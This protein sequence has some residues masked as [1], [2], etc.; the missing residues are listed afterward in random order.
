[1]S[2]TGNP[3]S[4]HTSANYNTG[5]SAGAG[6]ATDGLR[7]GDQILSA[8]LT[9]ILEGVHGNGIVMLEG[10]AVSGTNRNNPD[11]LPG[12][13][14][15]GTGQH[16]LKIQGGFVVLD[17]S[18]YKFADGYEND[19]TPDEITI[20]L[21]ANS[22]HKTGVTTALTS[23][24][25][26]IFT[27][28]LNADDGS[29]TKHVKFIQSSVVDTGTGVYPSSPNAYLID[30]GTSTSVKETI[31][32]A[33]VRAI[34]HDSPSGDNTGTNGLKIKITEINDK[35]VF[36]KPSPTYLVPMTKG[37]PS[38]KDSANSINS[39]SDLDA[40]HTEAGDFATS[41][42]GA[43]WMSHSTDKVTSG[44]T[45]LGDIGDD[46]LF[47]ASHESDGSA[48][49]LRLAPDR[50]YTGSP[51][52]VN[53]FTH[54]G[55]NIFIV[56]PGGSGCTLNPDNTSNEFAPGSILYIRNTNATSGHPINFDTVGSS[57]LNYQVT[58][59]QSA[60]I[61]RNNSSSNPKWSV[62]INA[63]SSGSGAV[64]AVNNKTENR[65]V[66]IG[67]T[68][69]ELDGEAQL[70]F[71]GT[72]LNVGVSGDGADLLLHS[73]TAAHVG[74]KWDHDDQTDGSLTLGADDHG[75]DFKAYGETSGKFIHWDASADTLFVTSTLD[76]DGTL[77]VGV[78]DTG[79]D[80]QFFG[81]AAGS[82]MLWDESENNL[83]LGGAAK[84]GIGDT[85][86]GTQLQIT[87]DG[88]TITLKNS[89][90]E[91]GE[92]GAESNIIFEDHAD[93]SLAKIEASHHG[94]ADDTKGKLIISTHT[95]SSLTTA[96]TIDSAQKTT[97]AGEVV[98]GGDLTVNGTTT[99]IN[100]TTMTTD[101]IILTLGG[102]TAPNANDAKDKGIEFRWHDGSSA[103]LGF[104][105][106]DESTGDFSFIP[107]ATNNSN[108][109]SGTQGTLNANI[110]GSLSGSVA[111][112]TITGT[113]DLTI[114]TDDFKVDTDGSNL[115]KVGINQATPITQLQI[116][117]T[118]L[119]S[120]T[121]DSGSTT[122]NAVVTLCTRTQF[123]SLKVFVS[124]KTDDASAFEAT[125]ILV[126]HNGASG[127][128][129]ASTAYG[130]VTIGGGAGG[131]P[132]AI[133]SYAVAL[134]GD[135]LQLTIDYNQVAG[136]NKDF[137]SNI[138]WIGLA[139]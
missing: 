10:G 93:V 92:G 6:R 112:T 29:S 134:S 50:I 132:S 83:I 99:T 19:G 4:G 90:A 124:S 41:P 11:F 67:S 42:L 85:A 52:G 14:T 15:T 53:H 38:N 111:A 88:P 13:I 114:N 133:A 8:S 128:T 137:T 35:R 119:Q 49:T 58:G 123:R 108:V 115:A 22:A 135:N 103:K 70:T 40:F 120:Q 121:V 105:G 26:C 55:P 78:D 86:P 1:M 3:L 17:S 25:E 39:H 30:D 77:T 89:V 118:G 97:L 82:Y 107:D 59:G 95:G 37:V 5:L 84:L 21:T 94:T 2:T 101:N 68:T 27:I 75:I 138:H 87:A 51:T 16:Q 64:S 24:K 79:Y 113:G 69:T 91:N 61:I 80:V 32:L 104:F 131:S 12:A 71:D 66:S 7:D 60:I 109:F 63:S 76:I 106:F 54:D 126:T 57:P 110:S 130:T 96:I 74:L 36:L 47:F 45:R 136:A 81:A 122:S 125:E 139:I 23:G 98:I 127:G 28:F 116:A 48:K 44:G 65:L 31:V 9:N 102:D 33:T 62:L 34:I 72:I 117:T 56:S 18:V 46:V 100:S 73:A 129:V 20:D 43:I